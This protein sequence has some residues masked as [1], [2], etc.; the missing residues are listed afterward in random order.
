MRSMSLIAAVAV[1]AIATPALA[2]LKGPCFFV[3]PDFKGDPMCIAPTQRLPSLGEAVKNKLM[4]VQIPPG[5]RVTVCEGT[6]LGGSC[7]TLS[8]SVP[9]FTTIGAAGKINSVASESAGAPRPTAQP[10]APSAGAPKAAPQ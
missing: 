7:Q 4:S 3:E 6:N 10:A 9:N 1:S 8:Q 5:V 2:Q